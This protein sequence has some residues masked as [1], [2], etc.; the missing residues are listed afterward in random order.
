VRRLWLQTALVAGTAVIE[1]ATFVLGSVYDAGGC[2][3]VSLWLR[4]DPSVTIP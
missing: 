3:Y 2:D 4:S 1:G